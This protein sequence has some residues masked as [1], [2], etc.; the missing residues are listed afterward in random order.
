VE[1]YYQR[2]VPD[3]AVATVVIAHGVAEHSGRYR[4]VGEFLAGRGYDTW[5]LDH[6]GHGRS[7]GRRVFV[8][9]FGAFVADLETLRLRAVAE[10]GAERPRFLIGHS[11]GGAIALAHTIDHTHAWSGL[12]LSGPAVEPGRGASRALVVTGRIASRLAPATG[13]VQLDA[14]QISRDPAVVQAYRDDPL[15]FT[16]KLTA[17]LAAELLD[18]AGRFP[19]QVLRLKLPILIVHGTDDALVPVEGSRN[20]LPRFGSADKTLREYPGL[21]HEVF[22]EPEGPEVLAGVATWMDERL[23]PAADAGQTRSSRPA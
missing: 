7:G 13:V 15:V 3:V 23:A 22:N 21:Y 18:R 6:R 12:V 17:R 14:S 8:E 5:V 11:M 1:I 10:G 9:R 20:L 19:A 16:G 2:W 4:H